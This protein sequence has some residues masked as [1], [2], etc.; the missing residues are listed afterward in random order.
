MDSTETTVESCNKISTDNKYIPSSCDSTNNNAS[1]STTINT[2]PSNNKRSKTS[3]RSSTNKIDEKKMKT[4]IR[5]LYDIANV[6]TSLNLIEKVQV[7]DSRK[8]SFR[9]IGISPKDLLNNSY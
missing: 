7:S 2:P 1:S 3:T 6:L 9:W 4:K 8:P 5:R